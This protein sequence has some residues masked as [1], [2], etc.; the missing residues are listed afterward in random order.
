MSNAP[1]SSLTLA[2]RDLRRAMEAKRQEAN[3][4]CVQAGTALRD[5]LLKTL[6]FPPHSI[7][8][9]YYRRGT[10]MDLLALTDALRAAGHVIALPVINGKREPLLFRS[11]QPGDALAQGHFGTQEPLPN[12][13]LVEPDILLVPLLAFDRQKGRLGYGGGYYD[14][15]L[16]D[17]RQRKKIVA[18]GIGYACQEVLEIPMNSYDARLDTIA[19]EKEVF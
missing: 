10:E 16:N 12:A 14:R 13:P 2:K 5:I 7:I 3:I 4:C 11:Y 8:A 6:Q 1:P 15:T 9:S 17:L 18:I 19:T